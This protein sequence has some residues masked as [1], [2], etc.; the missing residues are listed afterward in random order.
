MFSPRS[1]GLKKDGSQDIDPNTLSDNEEGSE[2][3]SIKSSVTSAPPAVSEAALEQ[4][5]VPDPDLLEELLNLKE[6]KRKM[7]YTI[8]EMSATTT[9]LER[10]NRR[11]NSSAGQAE[12]SMTKGHCRLPHMLQNLCK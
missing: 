1:V 12:A 6:D 7:T 10:E 11:L 4:G 2:S 9:R 3:G 5:K 8:K